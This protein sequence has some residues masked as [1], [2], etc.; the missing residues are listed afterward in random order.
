MKKLILIMFLGY[1]IS[2][3]AG[4]ASNGV[5][6]TIHFMSDGS[7]IA[8][9]SGARSDVPPCAINQ[10]SRFILD[11]TTAGGKVQASGLLSAYTTGKQVKIIGTG[12]CLV[13]SDTETINYFYTID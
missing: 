7:I 1:S 10:P 3:Y 11:G 12:D 13:R 4:T 6:S 5:F 9:T 2:S 8:Y